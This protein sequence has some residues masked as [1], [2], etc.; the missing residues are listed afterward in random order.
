MGRKSHVSDEEILDVFR[1]SE[2]PVLTSVELAEQFDITQQAA[3]NRLSNLVGSGEIERKKVG[4]KA[5]VWWL[6]E[7]H[8][9]KNSAAI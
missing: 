7:A 4:G 3:Y 1:E 8:S 5:V 9:S 2:D 6:D